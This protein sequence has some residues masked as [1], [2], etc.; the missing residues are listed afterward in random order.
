[1]KNIK[2]KNRVSVCISLLHIRDSI[3]SNKDNL[4]PWNIVGLSSASESFTHFLQD[5]SLSP[6][7]VRR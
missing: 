7:I 3:N 5:N 6:H 1:M 2:A 4:Q